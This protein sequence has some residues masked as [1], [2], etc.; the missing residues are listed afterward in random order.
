MFKSATM[1]NLLNI[2]FL[3]TKGFGRPS[4]A[5]FV[6]FTLALCLLAVLQDFLQSNYNQ[7]AF[8]LS[9]SLLF[10]SFWILALPV[11]LVQ[12]RL[13]RSKLP[14]RPTI[15]LPISIAGAVLLH[16]LLFSGLVNLL[17]ALLFDHTYTFGRV[18]YYSITEDLYKCVL[19]YSL[20]A[21]IYRYWPV[22]KPKTFVPTSVL[23]IQDG[24]NYTA[25]PIQEIIYI[26]AA[27]PYIA[28]HTANKQYLHTA[29]LK[30]ILG[31]L[32]ENQFVRIHKSTIV[33]LGE[34]A[35]YQSRLNGDYD[36]RLKNGTEL[37][38]SR[39]YSSTF[40]QY[41]EATSA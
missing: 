35:G 17:S 7:S 11:V 16:L 2:P 13:L 12:V 41:F 20:S 19:I 32:D 38:L 25:L 6:L 37:R 10:R 9:E 28:I 14:S 24:R 29:S 26:Q 34:V 30:S 5:V 27:S 22:S 8:F 31:E 33:N 15:Q 40:R 36:V 39:N 21:G 23:T 1:A 4:F 3:R 18:F